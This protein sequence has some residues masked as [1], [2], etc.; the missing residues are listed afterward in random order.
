MGRNWKSQCLLNKGTNQQVIWLQMKLGER[1]VLCTSFFLNLTGG[2]SEDRL[3]SEV[4]VVWMRGGG[5]KLQHGNFGQD[6]R[7]QP[8]T[9]R[10][11]R[12][13]SR[14][15]ERLSNSPPLGRT[16]TQQ[17][18]EHLALTG[19]ALSRRWD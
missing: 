5:H 8:F 18:S 11:V 16:K 15:P 10:V 17:A 9:R 19:P 2:C 12:H 1:S 14:S 4:S 13:W 3:S 6:R 7:N